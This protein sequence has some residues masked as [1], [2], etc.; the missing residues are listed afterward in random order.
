MRDLKF[1]RIAQLIAIGALERGSTP[2][3]LLCVKE[4]VLRVC[5][6]D[7]VKS[8][9]HLNIV[10]DFYGRGINEYVEALLFLN[11][12]PD[13]RKSAESV[14]RYFYLDMAKFLINNEENVLLVIVVD[15]D[16]FT[17]PEKTVNLEMLKQEFLRV[18]SDVLQGADTDA[19]RNYQYAFIFDKVNG[20][21]DAVRKSDSYSLAAILQQSSEEQQLS[22]LKLE[23]NE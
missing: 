8:Q 6:S 18:L 21:E 9:I 4:Q 14:L 23:E 10:Q 11:G 15:S 22:C 3:S 12:N 16:M 13:Y 5:F 7:Y 19:L 1:E 2:A 17:L 20:N